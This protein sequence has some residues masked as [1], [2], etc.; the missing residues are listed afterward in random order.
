ML[1]LI[2]D[3][4]ILVVLTVVHFIMEVIIELVMALLFLL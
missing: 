1:M 2:M 4:C 3:T